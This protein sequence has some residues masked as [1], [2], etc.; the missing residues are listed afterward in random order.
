MSKKSSLLILVA[1][2]LT[3]GF[4]AKSALAAST[5]P[6]TA[7]VTAENIS[8]SLDKSDVNF[9]TVAA[10]ST[11]DTTTAGVNDSITAT[12]NGNVLEDFNIQ[13][14]NSTST[15]AGWTLA[16]TAGPET[17]TLKY[18][19][20]TCDTSPSW[21]SVGI[22]PSYQKFADSVAATSGTQ[23]FDMQVGT[24]TTTSDFYEQSISVTVQAVLH[25]P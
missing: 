13:A 8:V 11:K 10:S 17:Y 24:P 16:G 12:N 5:A 4:V 18:C 9:G 15:G 23:T 6:V 2:V 22:S 1:A 20:V 25:T 7:K 21:T 14:A 19:T 3:A